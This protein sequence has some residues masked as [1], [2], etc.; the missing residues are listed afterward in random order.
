MATESGKDPEECLLEEERDSIKRLIAQHPCYNKD[1]QHKFGR[2]H[3][4]VA[5]KCNIKCKYCDRKYDCVNESRP[6]VTS[7][8]LTPQQ[9]LEKTQKV[10]KEYPFIKVVG[11]AGPGDPLAN[12]ETFETFKLIKQHFPDITLCLSTNGL[13]LPARIQDVLDSGVSTLTVTLNAIDPEIGAK[14]VD[15]V[16]YNGK[17]YRGVEGASIL[18]E[19]QL[20]GIRKAVEAGLVVKINTVLVPGINEDH[21]I[22]IAQKLNDMGVY[23]MNVMPLICQADFADWTA[24]TPQE[25]KAVQD[26]CEPYVQQMRHCRQCRSDAYGLLGKDLS[27]MSEERRNM[28]KV[29]ALKK[30]ESAKKKTSDDMSE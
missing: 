27:Q 24:P 26:S 3:L 15:H 30:A 9:A 21:I 17:T 13:A 4:S 5:P 1:A 16:N 12:D 29:D 14:I 2:I 11:I 7:E 22:E 10:L 6:G 18:L 8:V 23:I 20:E 25:R 28:V 19:N